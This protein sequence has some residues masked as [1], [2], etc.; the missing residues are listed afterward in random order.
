MVKCLDCGKTRKTHRNKTVKVICWE[1]YQL[2]AMCCVVKH[3]YRYPLNV[4]N[5][6]L[7]KEIKAKSDKITNK[8][9]ECT[10][11]ADTVFAKDLC[12]Y[13]YFH[14]KRNCKTNYSNI[15]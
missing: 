14:S 15:A 8:D 4:I 10:L 5:Q 13:H 3:P 2:C 6:F 12:K 7:G 11:C 9:K 1:D